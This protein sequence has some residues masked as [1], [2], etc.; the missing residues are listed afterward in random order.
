MDVFE[1]A[2]PRW[3]PGCGDFSVYEALKNAFIELGLRPEEIVI[4]CGI[5]CATFIWSYINTN[6]LKGIHGRVLPAATGVKLANPGL[7]VIGVS[8]DGD[9]YSIGGNHLVHTARRNVEITYI[10][11]DNG[12]FGNTRG[13]PS[14]TTP[15]YSVVK[16][17]PFRWPEKPV[18]PLLLALVSG[19]TFVAQG[20]VGDVKKLKEYFKEA[21]I[22][23][24]FSFINIL[25]VCPTF[26]PTRTVR[27][28]KEEIVYVE[29]FGAPLDNVRDAVDLV[30]SIQGEGK[31]PVGVIY[32]KLEPTYNELLKAT[33]KL[34]PSINYDRINE[35]AERELGLKM[36]IKD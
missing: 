21:I 26:N 29:E 3:C 6:A 15:I 24:G 22:H 10:V 2:K 4:V 30:L 36:L 35:I 5:G 1:R 16:N 18:N 27:E 14:P 31:N 8:G 17:Y 28:L 9:A 34:D 19:A 11:V 32:K 25:S 13:Q 12:V 7:K 20:F 33:G 23:R